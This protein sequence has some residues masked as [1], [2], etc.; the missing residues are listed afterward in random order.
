MKNKILLL[1]MATQKNP[2]THKTFIDRN[3]AANTFIADSLQVLRDTPNTVQNQNP[4]PTQERARSL[5]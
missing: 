2:A 1:P 4:A 3:Q 5:Q